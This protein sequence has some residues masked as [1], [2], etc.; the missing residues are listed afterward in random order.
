MLFVLRCYFSPFLL[1]WPVLEPDGQM[2]RFVLYP[3]AQDKEVKPTGSC[4]EMN[5]A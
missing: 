2:V 5:N 1:F 4:K 3:K